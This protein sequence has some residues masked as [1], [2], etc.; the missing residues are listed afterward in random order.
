MASAVK[1]RKKAKAEGKPARMG[2]PPAATET[3]VAEVCFPKGL[4]IERGNA[5][6]EFRAVLRARYPHAEVRHEPAAK[7]TGWAPSVGPGGPVWRLRDSGG[8][9]DWEVS[10]GSRF[11][12][13]KCGDNGDRST[14]LERLAEVASAVQKL[15][16]PPHFSRE[17]LRLVLAVPAEEA[18]KAVRTELIDP[19]NQFGGRHPLSSDPGAGG[20]TEASFRT[21]GGS[22]VRCRWG[23]AGS[24]GR[25]SAG[26]G[27]DAQ[28]E[29]AL[30][31]D[32]HTEGIEPFEAKEI[33]SAAGRLGDALDKV[34]GRLV[35]GRHSRERKAKERGGP[36]S[37]VGEAVYRIDL[38]RAA[39]PVED[40][41]GKPARMTWEEWNAI[42][43]T[44]HYV[45]V[46]KHYSGL[47]WEQM[48]YVLGVSRRTAYNW[49]KGARV[50]RKNSR[51]IAFVLRAV[52]NIWRGS[53]EKTLK[54]LLSVTDPT[55]GLTR[56]DLLRAGRYIDASAGLTPL[57]YYGLSD[58]LRPLGNDICFSD[59]IPDSDQEERFRKSQK[60]GKVGGFLLKPLK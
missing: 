49:Y 9:P 5:I 14:F 36:G 39:D 7:K 12:S 27:S 31:L 29:L 26:G 55:E 10:L 8:D 16:G 53:T 44:A 51:K 11:V 23:P 54:E 43:R 38:Q 3:F 20:V 32:M 46:T 33:V 60:V 58:P 28:P 13:L 47:T 34:L 6:E 57:S 4:D 19:S 42:P 21:D 2:K 35:T 1:H 56:M 45:R 40:K 24:N 15:F 50:T 41:D 52:S 59:M 22:Q 30:D 17:G 37:E 48:G 25:E 18:E